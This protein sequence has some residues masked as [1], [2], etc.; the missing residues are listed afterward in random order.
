MTKWPT[1][2]LELRA[3]A[4]VSQIPIYDAIVNI[5]FAYDTHVKAER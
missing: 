2:Q 4:F 1:G 3:N 5:V